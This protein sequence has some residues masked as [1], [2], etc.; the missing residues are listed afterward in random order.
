[1]QPW[2]LDDWHPKFAWFPVKTIRGEWCFWQRVYR[3]TWVVHTS[4]GDLDERHDYVSREDMMW[5]KLK[6]EA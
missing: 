4:P 3:R 6:G 5:M 2:I 1:M